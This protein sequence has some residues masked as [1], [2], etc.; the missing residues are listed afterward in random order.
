MKLNF[1]K[2]EKAE[3]KCFEK[4]LSQLIENFETLNS[5]SVVQRTKTEA[6]HLTDEIDKRRTLLSNHATSMLQFSL[7]RFSLLIKI[8]CRSTG[9]DSSANTD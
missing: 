5:A 4:V 6:L 8:Q 1:K 2:I 3:A 9:N 7:I